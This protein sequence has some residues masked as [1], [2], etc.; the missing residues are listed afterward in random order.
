MVGIGRRCRL[1]GAMALV[2]AP[3]LA[4]CASLPGNAHKVAPDTSRR[5]ARVGQRASREGSTAWRTAVAPRPT[6]QTSTPNRERSRSG[7][8]LIRRGCHPG[9]PRAGVNTPLRLIV[10]APCVTVHG[11]VGCIFVDHGDGDTHL[12]LSLDSG[13]SRYLTPGNRVWTCDEDKRPRMVIEVI[14]QHCTVRPDN[15]ADRGHFRS[16][17]IPPAGSHVYITGAWVLDTSTKH[18]ATL[19]SE[20]HPAFRIVVD[21]R[22]RPGPPD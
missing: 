5:A 11:V 15:C 17:R 22:S 21:R 9:D 4:G 7:A 18:G 6:V 10:K 13:Q 19:W 8:A 12:A 2:G 14:P 20:I 16:P 3:L 1:V